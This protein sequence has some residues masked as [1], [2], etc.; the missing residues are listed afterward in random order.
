[1]E[2]LDLYM[3]PGFS[4]GDSP[5]LLKENLGTCGKRSIAS[6]LLQGM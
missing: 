3:L 2:M 1:M 4:F 5:D 6:L